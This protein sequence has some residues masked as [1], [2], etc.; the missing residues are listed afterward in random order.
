MSKAN[1]VATG[2]FDEET[3]EP[4]YVADD[5]DNEEKNSSQIY[6]GKVSLTLDFL[7]LYPSTTTN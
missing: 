5:A 2:E 1:K 4:I 3:G 6:I 7:T